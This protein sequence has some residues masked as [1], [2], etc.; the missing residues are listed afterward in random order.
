MHKSVYYIKT[1]KLSISTSRHSIS[2]GKSIMIL[3]FCKCKAGF[4]I[5][6]LLSIIYHINLPYRGL[7]WKSR[8]SR[9]T[10]SN[11][12]V[13]PQSTK[14]SRARLTE[15][16]QE[17]PLVIAT[18]V[19]QQHKRCCESAAL[20][21]PTNLENSAVA[22]E[23]EKGQFS[24]QSLRKAVPQMFKQSHNCTPLI[25]EQSNAQNSPSQASTVCEPW[26]SRC[27]SWI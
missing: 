26:T 14:W 24:F 20:N 21:M 10:W 11:M 9:D 13:C 16:C 18:L 7:E 17:N 2:K 1:C 27:S 15:F 12:Q 3:E 4:I 19:F 22:T 23:L 8:K 5:E 6:K 25:L